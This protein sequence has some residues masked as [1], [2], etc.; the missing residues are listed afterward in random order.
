VTKWVLEKIAQ[1]EAQ[2]IFCQKLMLNLN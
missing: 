1:S 2:P